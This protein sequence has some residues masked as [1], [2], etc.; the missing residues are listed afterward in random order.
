MVVDCEILGYI[1]D[2]FPN[3]T[4]N[5]GKRTN[6]ARQFEV[7]LASEVGWILAYKRKTITHYNDWTLLHLHWRQNVG[8]Y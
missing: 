3:K 6:C 1:K 2:E 5:I 8:G 4:E 7:G